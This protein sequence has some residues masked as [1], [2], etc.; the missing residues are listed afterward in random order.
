[1]DVSA[2]DCPVCRGET[3]HDVEK[4]RGR[5]QVVTCR[6][7]GR[8]H[9]VVLPETVEVPV[10]LSRDEETTET[11]IEVAEDATIAVGDRMFLLDG[12][13]EVTAVEAE[14]DRRH[15]ELVAGEIRTL[16]ARDIREVRIPVTIHRGRTSV[17]LETV[18]A[19]DR[20][21]V[22]GEPLEVEGRTLRIARIKAEDR[23]LRDP[24]EGA[25]AVEV[26]RVYGEDR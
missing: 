6:E 5:E 24:G 22:V 14:D 1:M 7:C 17:S 8:T 12:L 16:W 25:K 20:E 23:V 18:A 11:A 26:V 19:P 2:A 4:Q 21:L 3:L 13:A 15:D 9:H 10:Q